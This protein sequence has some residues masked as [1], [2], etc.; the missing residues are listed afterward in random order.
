MENDLNWESGDAVGL[1]CDPVPLTMSRTE[2]KQSKATY[3]LEG[4]AWTSFSEL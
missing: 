4:W 2:A 1:I 3:A